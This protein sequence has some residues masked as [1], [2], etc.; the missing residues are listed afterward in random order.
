MS[1][2]ATPPARPT[3]G[4][5]FVAAAVA[6]VVV[7]GVEQLTWQAYLGQTLGSEVKVGAVLAASIASVALVRSKA[8][9]KVAAAGA[10]CAVVGVATGLCA[11]LYW[12]AWPASVQQTTSC[13]QQGSLVVELTGDAVTRDYG[14]VSQASYTWANRSISLRILWPDGAEALSAGHLVEVTGT[15][16][17]PAADEG[18]RYNHQQGYAG[19]VLATTVTPC[20][21]A[22]GV[23]GT[24]CRFRDACFAR[25]SS[26]G[27][28][29]A[30]LLAGILIGNRTLYANTELEQAFR[31]CGLAH[32]MAVSGTH[33]A[34]VGALA[35][36]L[37]GAT[38]LSRR[39]RAVAL[40]L[41]LAAYVAL[42]GFAP[43]AERAWVMCMVGAVGGLAHRRKDVCSSLSICVVA[44][45]GLLPPLAFSVGYQLSVL[46]MVGLVVLSPLI[47]Y[48]F[49]RVLPTR[50][51]GLA[52]PVSATVGASM[53]TIPV[54]APLFCQLPLIAPVACVLAS[55]LITA[56]LG[57]GIPALLVSAVCEPFGVLL[58]QG[59]GAVA[60][61]CAALVRV[62]ACVPGACAPLDANALVVG[63]A[64]G[65][66][67]AALWALW[68]VPA[69]QRDAK[70]YCA[71]SAKRR[72]R[73]RVAGLC[74]APVL[75]LLV[76]GCGGFAGCS[77]VSGT[78]VASG[79]QVIQL[80]VGQ[81]D[82]MLIRDGTAAVLI[83]TGEE[84]DLLLSGLA[85]AGV[86]HLDAVILTH[87][88]SD[89]T[90][91]LAALAGVVSVSA[92]YIQEDLLTYS[93]E[94]SVLA[95]AKRV[96]EG[97]ASGLRL[98]DKLT[99]GHFTLTIMGPE[100]G[101]ESENEDSLVTLI[102]YDPEADG[103][104]NARGLV[105][106]D[107]E[108]EALSA[109]VE[110]VGDVDFIKVPHHG[111]AGGLSAS[112]LDE[113]KPE[114]AL[115]SVGADN[116][117]GHPTQQILSLLES[118]HSAIYRT[119]ERGDICLDFSAD[120]LHVTCQK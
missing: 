86:S 29:A 58:L 12:G 31:T 71:P 67:A 110:R 54:T 22:P 61:A 107:A 119:D 30:G 41:L 66:C 51:A 57:L 120:A 75:A 64:F 100:S 104:A 32:L 96:C 27:G 24:V 15:L 44:F 49:G 81:G 50:L 89:H 118:A 79:A 55:P 26:V 78:F 93:G 21:Y 103:V 6:W 109:I 16:S 46:A 73:L 9:R 10:L 39:A 98:G 105:S 8:V 60:S 45:L 76:Y 62:L 13:L 48:W 112:E 90:G 42:T 4:F 36:F 2:D 3:L 65:A 25:I 80:D 35:G 92:V 23:R 5:L 87:K 70:T 99:V 38:R 77:N 116:T 113:L 97:G 69:V 108:A 20:G 83:D 88:D 43:S 40:G 106:G 84:D 85:R 114:V 47:A 74:V 19:M 68:P 101:G 53:L 102:E 91:A 1:L 33:L 7:M 59:A 34:V 17:E 28:D 111:S 94:Q 115:I 117:Y 63:V 18:G 14:V 11:L 95:A 37:L 72:L 56:A 82:C 52:E